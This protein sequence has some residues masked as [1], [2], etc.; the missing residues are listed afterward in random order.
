MGGYID[1]DASDFQDTKNSLQQ[2]IEAADP[3]NAESIKTL[4]NEFQSFLN[5]I[6][7]IVNSSNFNG[8]N[9]INGQG[10]GLS[11][12]L[13]T[14]GDTINICEQD[15]TVEGLN[16][17]QYLN[18]TDTDGNI[19]PGITASNASQAITDI[20]NVIKKINK[21]SCSLEASSHLLSDHELFVDHDHQHIL[22]MFI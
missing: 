3:D 5:S 12:L 13:D 9:L 15:L 21:V 11:F 16:L 17:S 4:N 8:V 6:T 1:A 19:I 7:T 22:D 18:W 10:N 2:A 20:Q 14:D